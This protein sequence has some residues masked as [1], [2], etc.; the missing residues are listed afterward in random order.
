[1][2]IIVIVAIFVFLAGGIGY[3]ESDAEASAKAF[4]TSAPVG[5]ASE[6]VTQAAKE[7]GESRLRMIHKDSVTVG[8]TGLPPY[9]RHLCT[10]ELKDGKVTRADYS[11]LD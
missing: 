2:R 3:L 6:V 4:C 9:S 11:Y 7:K 1:M 5:T 10:I 8:F